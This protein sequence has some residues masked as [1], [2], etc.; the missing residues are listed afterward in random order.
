MIWN[1]EWVGISFNIN[2]FLGI[3]FD[4]DDDK[5]TFLASHEYL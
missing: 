4:D 2:C 3:H 1:Y 5:D